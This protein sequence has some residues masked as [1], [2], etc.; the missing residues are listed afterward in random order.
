MGS[1][2]IQSLLR[3]KEAIRKLL[4]AVA[5]K[6]GKDIPHLP[7]TKA[8]LRQAPEYGGQVLAKISPD[9]FLRLTTAPSFR[10]QI[11]REA[12]S[13]STY[14]NYIKAGENTVAPYLRLSIS[15]DGK[16]ASVATHEGRHRA[17]SLA[18]AGA[19]KM[20]V[21]LKIRKEGVSSNDLRFTDLPDKIETE[22]TNE[23]LDRNDLLEFIK[24]LIK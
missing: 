12:K 11:E 9:N 7:L 15:E 10:R 21:V 5:V 16:L 2:R 3:K 4:M 14:R 1:L 20:P 6:A 13:L 22:Y 18:S 8:M 24:D 23:T 17:A 19:S